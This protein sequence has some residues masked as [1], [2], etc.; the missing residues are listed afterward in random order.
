[1]VALGYP[2]SPESKPWSSHSNRPFGMDHRGNSTDDRP[3]PGVAAVEGG[4]VMGLILGLLVLWLVLVI[5]GFAVKTLLW[6]AIVGLV[7]FAVT[8]VIGAIRGRNRR[9]VLR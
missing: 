3:H 5:V 1:M 2:V 8:S 6:L 4:A 7:L 9:G